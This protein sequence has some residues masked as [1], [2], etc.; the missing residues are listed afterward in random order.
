MLQ[1][2]MDMYAAMSEYGEAIS[3]A[4]HFPQALENSQQCMTTLGRIHL[5]MQN[6]AEAIEVFN[7]ALRRNP[8]LGEAHYYKA[9]AYLTMQPPALEQA[10][11]SAQQARNAGYADANALVME[12][13]S[14]VKG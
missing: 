2:L 4:K 8:G 7:E 3:A 5:A 6:P 10:R 9:I 11:A 14:R 12:I 1:R 13:D